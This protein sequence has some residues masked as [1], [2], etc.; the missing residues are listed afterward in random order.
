MEE[1]RLAGLPGRVQDEVL[2]RF[3]QVHD[4]VVKV[5]ERIHHI[6]PFRKTQSGRVK[7]SAHIAKIGV[8]EGTVVDKGL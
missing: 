4:I 3:D 8:F 5:P 2:L 7:K 6:V 1:G